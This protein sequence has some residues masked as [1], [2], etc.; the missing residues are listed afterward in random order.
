MWPSNSRTM[1]ARKPLIVSINAR[2]INNSFNACPTIAP[3]SFSVRNLVP[4]HN[5]KGRSI[6]P[7]LVI[8]VN[9]I[10]HMKYCIEAKIPPRRS[11]KPVSVRISAPPKSLGN[12]INPVPSDDKHIRTLFQI[13]SNVSMRRR[14]TALGR[15]NIPGLLYEPLSKI[16][17]TYFLAIFPFPVFSTRT[18]MMSEYASGSFSFFAQNSDVSPESVVFWIISATFPYVDP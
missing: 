8:S 16:S 14:I 7:T 18:L 1:R 5:I 17:R 6:Q 9:S 4:S 15:M 12:G 13:F 10:A 2:V 3:T 11:A